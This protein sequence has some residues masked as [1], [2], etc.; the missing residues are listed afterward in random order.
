MLYVI[1]GNKLQ[2]LRLAIIHVAFVAQRFRID[3]LD[4]MREMPV[5]EIPDVYEIAPPFRAIM[6]RIYPVHLLIHERP[7]VRN[8]LHTY[9]ALVVR[10]CRVD[11]VAKNF[12]D[13]PLVGVW[14]F[15][16]VAFL[17]CEKFGFCSLN[18]ISETLR[19]G[20]HSFHIKNYFLWECSRRLSN[21]RTRSFLNADSMIGYYAQHRTLEELK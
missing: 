16:G 7:D 10:A 20:V 3:V 6:L 19:D 8:L 4:N 5:V 21:R 15:C 14:F 9:Y 17:D 2:C 11:E 18:G 12:L 1:L 13:R